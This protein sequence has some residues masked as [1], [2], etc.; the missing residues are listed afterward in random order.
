M[1][2]TTGHTSNQFEQDLQD[3][4]N[5]AMDMGTLVE[6]QVKDAVKALIKSKSK[7]GRR[8]EI[9]DDVVDRFELD[10]D[11]KS[12]RLLALRQP[13]AGDLRFIF[14]II[15]A[16][17]DMERIGDEAKK[18]AQL[19]QDV[20]SSSLTDSYYKTMKY[21]GKSV[22]SVLERSLSA[23]ARMDVEEAKEILE[24]DR[25][26]DEEFE[27]FARLLV[28][29]M[30][31]NPQSIQTALNVLWSA[32]SLERISDHAINLCEYVVFMVEGEDV[33]HANLERETD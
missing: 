4:H 8:V 28:T 19:S 32:R 31:S 12:T 14:S 21:L 9:A 27:N 33:R 5:K 1:S 13:A 7:L 18:I 20:E 22:V 29:H 10:V 16:T 15:K 11:E 6:R 17:T 2:I 24:S 25:E 3:L 30:M 23:F 26:V